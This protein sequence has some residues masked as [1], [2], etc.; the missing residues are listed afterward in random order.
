MASAY[1][2]QMTM[3]STKLSELLHEAI[4]SNNAS[5]GEYEAMEVD[6]VFDFIFASNQVPLSGK[7]CI[8]IQ[9]SIRASLSLI[10]CTNLFYSQNLSH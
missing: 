8:R 3:K 10:N 6:V 2:D 5:A 9:V 7:Q 4:A 1:D